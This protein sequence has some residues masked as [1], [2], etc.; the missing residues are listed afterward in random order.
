MIGG[1]VINTA[2]I[3][4]NGSQ[5]SE[6]MASLLKNL[7]GMNDFHRYELGV[8]FSDKQ[9]RMEFGSDATYP[10]VAIDTEHIGS[11]KETLQY[12]NKNGML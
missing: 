12:M 6:R 1:S 11:M 2:V 3:Y 10:Q 9:F 8:H 5:E 7:D 4:S